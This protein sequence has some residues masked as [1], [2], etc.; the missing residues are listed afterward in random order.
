MRLDIEKHIAQCLSCAQTKGTTQTA[1]IFE[2][3]LPAG[4]YEIVSIDLL[5]LPRNIQGS[6]YVF[7]CVDHFSRFTVLASLPN[8]FAITV[9]YAIVSYLICPCTTPRVLLSDNGAEF[10]NQV[11]RDICTQFHIQQ[12]FITSHHPTSNGL[13]ERTNWKILEVFRHLAGHLQE[14]WEY[15]LSPVAASING[16]A[17]SSIGKTTLYILFWS[18]KRLPCDV[19]VP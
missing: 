1:T 3:P 8:K 6:M 11:L 2:Y 7:V 15:W 13:V 17:N 16:S 14:T 9:A 12:I 19:L 4:P 18:E 5:Q 10:K